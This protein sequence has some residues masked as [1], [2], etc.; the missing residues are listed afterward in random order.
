VAIAASVV[1]V[2]AL[3][4]GAILTVEDLPSPPIATDAATTDGATPSDTGSAAR[5]DD[6]AGALGCGTSDCGRVVFVSSRESNSVLGGLDGA[7]ATCTTLAKDP[8][9]HP[10]VKDRTFKAWLSDKDVS[11]GRRLDH[12]ATRFVLP[13]GTLVAKNWDAFASAAHEA[14]IN[15]DERNEQAH[16][17]VWTGTKTNGD[18]TSSL[19]TEWA[20]LFGLGTLGNTDSKTA[21]WTQDGTR[22]CSTSARIYCI[23]N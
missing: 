22:I 23:E 12:G 2:A 5:V 16:G 10:R 7:D 6:A 15:V 1:L 8:A 17:L 9:S 21:D 18:A 4:C 11:A 3:G 20:G 19:C 13:N 14:A